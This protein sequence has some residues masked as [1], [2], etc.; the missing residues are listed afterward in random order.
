MKTEYAE[1]SLSDQRYFSLFIG[2]RVLKKELHGLEGEDYKIP[3]YSA[4]PFKPFGYVKKSNVTDFGNDFVLWGIDGNFEFNIIRK[5][6]LFATT[7]HCGAIRI[8]NN[9]I[10]PEYLVAS[11]I[12][13]KNEYGFD[14]SL[15]A[16]LK[17]IARIHVK[18]PT[19][20][21][22]IGQITFNED[23]QNVIAEN[24][25]SMDS[26]RNMLLSLGTKLRNQII[27]IPDNNLS[28]ELTVDQI[29]DLSLPTNHSGFN[30]DF[31]LDHAGTIPVYS[32][33]QDAESVTYGFIEDNVKGIKYYED[34]LT[35]NKDGSAGRVFFRQGRFAP[36]EK[37]VPLVLKPKYKSCIDYEYVKYMLERK[38]L[39]SGFQFS[40]KA[41]KRRVKELSIPFPVLKGHN[42]SIPD[43]ETQKL[44]AKRYREIDG[45][46]SEMISKLNDVTLS[47]SLVKLV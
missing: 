33:S 27:E 22:K 26:I 17:N 14:R 43:I 47:T 29:F 46:R 37:V 23:F 19:I 40:N 44:I 11:L 5:G 24:F 3:L 20:E 7:D 45:I 42:E 16:S 18:I 13:V 15:R 41:A 2:K 1:V 4:N 30:M 31:I 35:Y 34:C 28:L 8:R 39:E 25:R 21:S 36:S 9:S 6:N 10:L 38:A 12:S 32:T